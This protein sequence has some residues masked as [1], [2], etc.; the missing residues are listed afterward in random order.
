MTFREQA[1]FQ[2]GIRAAVDMARI[3]AITIET[4][5]GSEGIRQRAAV[6]ALQGFADG[7]QDAFLASPPAE[8]GPV[9][10]AFALVAEEPGSAGTIECPA[11]RGR[12]AWIR[13]SHNGHV[14]GQCE[15]A[16]CL[17]WMQ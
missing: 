5:P 6:A 9:L 13:D 14:H 7:A 3:A 8:A 16:G 10:K 17:S 11:C 15:T 12:L 4:G 1:A 2:A